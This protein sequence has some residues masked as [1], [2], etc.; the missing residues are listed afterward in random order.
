MGIAPK[1][2]VSLNRKYD[3]TVVFSFVYYCKKAI[4]SVTCELHSL[5]KE[6][7]NIIIIRRVSVL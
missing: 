5:Q 3:L 2:K 6:E 7:L 4:K 1:R